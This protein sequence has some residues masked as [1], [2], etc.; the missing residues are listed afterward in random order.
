MF[1]LL[2]LTAMGAAGDIDAGEFSV[3]NGAE[4]S[5]VGAMADVE[6]DTTTDH[7]YNDDDSV[8]IQQL[9]S[10]EDIALVEDARDETETQMFRFAKQMV[11]F[12][13]IVGDKKTKEAVVIDGA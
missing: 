12:Q 8:F 7:D 10:G 1:P 9:L 11:N 6:F 3:K 5:E 4:G 2:F 13:Y